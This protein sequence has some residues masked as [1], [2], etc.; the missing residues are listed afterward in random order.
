MPSATLLGSGPRDGGLSPPS[1]VRTGAG[2]RGTL[3]YDLAKYVLP[4]IAFA[5]SKELEEY[6]C[7]A[8]CLTPGWIRS[9]AM[10]E[11]FEVTEDDWRSGCTKDPH[12]CISETPRFVG[13]AAAALAADPQVSRWNGRSL[14]A[15]ELSQEYGFTDLDGTQPDSWRYIK[16][17]ALAGKPAGDGPYRLRPTPRSND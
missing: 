12:F 9:E 1:R 7:T 5:L 10:L 14:H 16:E 13:R 15:F 6:G 17:V 4:R 3:F 2:N 8:V 11:I